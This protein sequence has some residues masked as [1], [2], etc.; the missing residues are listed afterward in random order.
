[1]KLFFG[2]TCS[3][4]VLSLLGA[5]AAPA[6]DAA[7][8]RR[9]VL[10]VTLGASV[11]KRWNTVTHTTL[12]GC[13]VSIRSIGVRKATLRSKRPTK[14]V[15]TSRARRVSYAPAAVEFVTVDVTGSGE[16]T[17]TYE[18]P[19]QQPAEHIA[20]ARTRRHVSGAAFRFFRSKRNEISFRRARLPA[21][22]GSCPRQS[23]TLRAILPGLHQAEGGIS[24]SSLTNLRVAG[25]T[26]IGSADVESD[27]DGDEE[28]RVTERIRWSMTFTR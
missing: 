17:T 26:A 6:R 24:E 22:S 4:V 13:D 9:A 5:L 16:Q 19:C 11:T 8:A 15:V 14:V 3:A 2:F 21:G 20:C 7:P 28:G 1:M 10:K 23:A 18:P 12:N 25:Q 27:L